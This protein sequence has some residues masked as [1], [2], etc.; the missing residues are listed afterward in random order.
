MLV[1]LLG[2]FGINSGFAGGVL[3]FLVDFVGGFCGG[4]GVCLGWGFAG[5]VVCCRC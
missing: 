4:V 1:G 3:A 2:G 5:L